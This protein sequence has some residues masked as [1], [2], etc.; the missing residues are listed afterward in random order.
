MR[1]TSLLRL[2]CA[3]GMF[4]CGTSAHAIPITIDF[5]AEAVGARENG[6]SVAGVS[7][8]DTV[9]ADLGIFGVAEGLGARSLLVGRDQ[10]GS[11]LEM[12]FGFDID[13]LS[14]SFG[15]DDPANTN[16][17]DLAVLTLFAGLAQVGEVTLTLNR[18]DAMNQTVTF[19]EIGSGLLFDRAL[20]A[21]TNATL[22]RFTGGSGV[23]VGSTEVV[24]NITL[25]RVADVIAV[26]E[27]ANPWLLA[28]LFALALMFSRKRARAS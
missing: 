3:L 22:S 19:G 13:V 28:G 10:D 20:F 6:F 17:G 27:P 1:T 9:G 11:A 23:A 21:F 16:A 15:N 2:L 12:S 26:S 7:F 25:N 18:D 8:A 5:E 24:D 14:L 4:A